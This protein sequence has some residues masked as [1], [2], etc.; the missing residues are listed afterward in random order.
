MT[1][2]LLVKKWV[3]VTAPDLAFSHWEFEY[4]PREERGD[5]KDNTINLNLELIIFGVFRSD[6][7]INI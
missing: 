7:G 1:Q 3:G 6:R 5:Y 2:E 4:P